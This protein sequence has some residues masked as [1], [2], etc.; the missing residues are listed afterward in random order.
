MYYLNIHVCLCFFLVSIIQIWAFMN[1]SF[2]LLFGSYSA[3]AYS[4]H[5]YVRIY[6]YSRFS[7]S[8]LGIN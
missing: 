5:A 7:Q 3:L 4:L 6:I 2:P 8:N 1:S